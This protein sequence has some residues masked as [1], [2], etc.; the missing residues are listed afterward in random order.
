MKGVGAGGKAGQEKIDRPI[1]P[2]KLGPGT[3][4]KDVVAGDKVQQD[5]PGTDRPV[6]PKKLGPGTQQKDNVA[7]DKAQQDRPG[8]DRPVTPKKL[9]PGTNQKDVVA[10]DKAQQDRPGTDRP[11]TPKKLGPG[12]NTQLSDRAITSNSKTPRK[13]PSNKQSNTKTPPIPRT[14]DRRL[15]P[16]RLETLP[17][18]TSPKHYPETPPRAPS[19]RQQRG[20]PHLTP[21]SPPQTD[22]ED[23]TSKPHPL[24]SPRDM[25]PD[26]Q[27]EPQRQQTPDP[28]SKSQSYIQQAQSPSPETLNQT[29]DVIEGALYLETHDDSMMT[30]IREREVAVTR[31]DLVTL[32]QSELDYLNS[33]I[34]KCAILRNENLGLVGEARE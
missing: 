21:H 14:P 27:R 25:T 7:G 17:Q 16:E 28:L 31:G 19:L 13:P 23:R 9:G 34:G 3:E 18:A 5:R 8:T 32:D 1:T 20:S 11:R 6:T 12:T 26:Q 24:K 4:Q 10:G 15:S 30:E 22:I 33:F 2:K 29:V